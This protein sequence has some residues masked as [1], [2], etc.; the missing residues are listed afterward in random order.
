MAMHAAADKNW[1]NALRGEPELNDVMSDPII[2]TLM[3]RDGVKISELQNVVA[4]FRCR[5]RGFGIVEDA[6]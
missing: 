3:K 2:K 5:Q 1:R 4:E 6:A